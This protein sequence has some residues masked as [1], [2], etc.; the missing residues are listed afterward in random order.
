MCALVIVCGEF[1]QFCLLP[2]RPP[3]I[4]GHIADDRLAASTDRNVLHRDFLFAAGPIAFLSA[5]TGHGMSSA[6]AYL[7]RV[8]PLSCCSKCRSSLALSRRA[9]GHDRHM[10]DGLCVESMTSTGPWVAPFDHRQHEIDSASRIGTGPNYLEELIEN[11][12]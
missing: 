11:A 6:P 1:C 5:S 7:K 4:L 10:S 9:D 12:G 2:P 8:R 3:G